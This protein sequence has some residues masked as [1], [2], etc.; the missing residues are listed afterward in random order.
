[1]ADPGCT[2]APVIT[3]PSLSVASTVHVPS[4]FGVTMPLS[5]PTPQ[6]VITRSV[7]AEAVLIANDRKRFKYRQFSSIFFMWHSPIDCR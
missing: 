7:A 5:T 1:M 3:V 6:A 2:W 4:P